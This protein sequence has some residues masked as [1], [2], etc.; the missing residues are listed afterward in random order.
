MAGISSPGVSPANAGDWGLIPGSRRSGG[1]GNGDS[2]I[3]AWENPWTKKPGVLQSMGS[4]RTEQLNND[5]SAARLAP[6]MHE[7][8]NNYLLNI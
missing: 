3:V 4:D 1:E 2:S 7:V 8:L 5:Q 6:G